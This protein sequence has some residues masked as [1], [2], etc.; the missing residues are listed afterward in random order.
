MSMFRAEQVEFYPFVPPIEIA[1]F[2]TDKT[3]QTSL[4]TVLVISSYLSR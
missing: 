2:A 4:G 3:D 1:D